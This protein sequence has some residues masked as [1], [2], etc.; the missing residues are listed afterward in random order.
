MV[1]MPT[2]W[3]EFADFVRRA[4]HDAVDDIEP[5]DDGLEPIRA[6][7]PAWSGLRDRQA[8]RRRHRPGARRGARHG[9]P[10]PQQNRS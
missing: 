10:G 1:R 7:I 4:L 9:G 6:R 8:A 3:H 2:Q 5:E